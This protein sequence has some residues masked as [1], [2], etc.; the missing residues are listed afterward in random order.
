M[1][2]GELAKAI[3]AELRGDNT[4]EVDGIHTLTD[5]SPSQVSFLTNKAYKAQLSTTQA[6]A[7]ILD[8]AM[9][10]HY[11]GN[12]LVM[13][14]P[15]AGYARTVQC[16]APNLKRPAGVHASAV[17]DSSVSLGKNVYVGPNAV[18]EH[19]VTIGDNAQIGAGTIIGPNTKL[20]R[21]CELAAN[22]T[23]AH[24]ITIGDRAV[25][26]S[27]TVIGS[28][29]FGFA[30]DENEWV[31][32]P[33]LGSVVIGDN[34]DIGASCTI[35]RGTFGDTVIADGV[36]LDNQV[37]IAHNVTIGKNT[38]MAGRCGVAGSTTIGA[39]CLMGGEVAISGHLT[40]VDGCT[41]TGRTSVVANVT[42]KGTY[43]SGLVQEPN[44]SWRR[45]V[46]R[47]RQLDDMMKR[48]KVL[49]SKNNNE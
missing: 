47:F 29:G 30:R 1:N 9:A 12:A 6:A 17:V 32:I 8:A 34:V 14:H 36:K 10:E 5:A 35:D 23:L 42:E 4:V 46:I 22:V 41:F 43:S 27:S 21:D 24:E 45:N 15:H 25:I 49:E 19:G 31:T 11:E 39:N 26:Q 2:L 13:S 3:G 44:A 16:F 7:V 38:V 48:L 20:G 33:Q 18:I 28:D 37:H 40:I